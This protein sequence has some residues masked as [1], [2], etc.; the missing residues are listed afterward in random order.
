MNTLYDTLSTVLRTLCSPRRMIMAAALSASAALSA[1]TVA[2]TGRLVDSDDGEA[3]PQATVQMLHTD[4][5]FVAGTRSSDNGVFTVTASRGGSYLIKVSSVGYTTTYKDVSVSDGE[6][7]SL[8]KIKISQSAT[9]LEGATVTEQARKV[10]LSNDTFIYNAAAYRTPDGSV[11]E[12]LLKRIPG[13]TIDDEGTITHNGKEVTKIKVDGKEFM[14]GDTKTAVKYL[15]TS[16]VDKVKAYDEKSDMARM[17]GIEDGEEETVLDFGLKKGMNKGVFGEISGSGGT[18][19]RFSSRLMAAVMSSKLRAMALGG[20]NNVNDMGFPGGGGG[21]S[22]G[23]GRQG[24]TTTKTFAVNINYD[25]GNRLQGDGSVRW[26]HSNNDAATKS[27][28]ENFVTT[29]GAFSNSISQEY[30]RS[31]SWNAQM[32]FEWKPDTMT[33]ILFRPTMSISYSDGISTSTSASYGDDPYNY[34]DDPLSAE[35]IEQMDAD[36]LMVNRNASTSIT[37]TDSKS[38]GGSL[39][40]NRRFGNEGRNINVRLEGNYGTSDGE[41]LSTNSVHLYQVENAL[42][43]DSTYQTNRYRLTPT[44]NSSFSVQVAYSEPIAHATYLQLSYKF[45]YSRSRSDQTTYDFSNLGETFFD[46]VSP[47]YRSWGRYLSLLEEPISDYLDTDLSKYSE[48]TNYTHDIEL[49][50]RAVRESYNFSAGVLVQPQRSRFT[51]D[52][53]GTHSDTVRTVVNVAPTIDFRYKFSKVSQLDVRYKGTTSQPSLSDLVDI[54]D[55]SDPLNITKGNPGLKPSFTHNFRAR[56]NNFIEN[57]YQAMAANLSFQV[58][59]NSIGNAVTY[60][61]TTGGRTTTPQ[62]ING[63]WNASG[64]LTYS[65]SAD[66]AGYWNILT[67]TAASY[68]NLVGYV[69]LDQSAT[70]SKN[71]TK[72]LTLS[73]NMEI[74]YRN[75]WLEVALLGSLDYNRLRNKLQSASNIDTWQFSYGTSFDVTLPW[76]TRISTD[77]KQNSRRGYSDSSMNTNELV[78]NAQLSHSFLRGNAL[79]VML[80]FYDILGKQSNFSRT[81][82]AMSRSDVEY[83]SI[84]SYAMIKVVYR[85]N[86]FGNK[87]TRQEMRRNGRPD[88]GGRGGGG[89]RPGGADGPPDGGPGGPG[90]GPGGGMGGPPPGM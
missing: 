44:K 65:F 18:E 50:F 86:V 17:T 57:H 46:G 61:E 62:N 82:N 64:G 76:G 52:Y 80:Q 29:S 90:G 48:Y 14:T 66:T 11:I 69:N 19:D 73:E 12:E 3:L 35:A 88:F 20:A 21:G 74:S 72:S 5:T 51:Q 37:Y 87:K 78:W 84:N 22:F 23:R 83:N 49:T 43:A 33:N 75:D 58:V 60:D 34:V 27:S 63:N 9:M 59:R 81:I 10:V 42:G 4:S 40:Y 47:Y 39:Q 36:G 45:A 13:V 41:S 30:T 1:Q 56:Y 28:S 53:L 6:Q 55:D 16:I 67:R 79:S 2:V 32:R 8:G 7:K 85:I 68:Q 15:P 38:F 54:T 70:A 26:N 31:D 77:I 25:D 89:E 24:L 71:T